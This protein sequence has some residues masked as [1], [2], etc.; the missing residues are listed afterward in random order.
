MRTYLIDTE[1]NEYV[2][3]LLKTIKHPHNMLECQFSVLHEKEVVG[4]ETIFV[5]K[6]CGL[7][8]T[9]KDQKVWE[10]LAKLQLPKKFLNVDT[11]YDVY[12]GF[13]PSGLSGN[14]SGELLTQMPGKVVK[15]NVSVGDVVK[16]GQTLIILE[17]MKMENEIK[18]SVDGV[19][20]NILV[21]VNQALE[22]GVLM[23]E[24]EENE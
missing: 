2:Y 19:V 3:D 23:M 9:S 13:R 22:Q 1:K 5:K 17:A 24:V 11:V 18:S 4:T 12:R 20:K 15:I 6:H 21:E 7:Y 10:K 8:F 14:D 16:A